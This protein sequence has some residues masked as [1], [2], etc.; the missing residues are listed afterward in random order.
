M[1][2]INDVLY[3][4]HQTLQQISIIKIY[5]YEADKTILFSAT[6]LC[7]LLTIQQFVHKIWHQIKSD[8]QIF[9]YC[10]LS[11]IQA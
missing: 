7:S 10:L 8:K 11:D 5:L 4:G 9:L 1:T 3:V 2:D 6:S